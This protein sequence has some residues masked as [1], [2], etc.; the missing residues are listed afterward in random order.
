MLLVTG[1]T[2]LE[3]LLPAVGLL[4]EH[5]EKPTIATAARLA[6]AMVLA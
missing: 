6:A 2:L 4:L 3:L 5:P 1:W